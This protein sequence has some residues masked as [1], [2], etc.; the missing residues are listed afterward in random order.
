MSIIA[1]TMATK[2]WL[3]KRKQVNDKIPADMGNDPYISTDFLY[4]SI[5]AAQDTLLQ[6]IETLSEEEMIWRPYPET[7]STGFLIWHVARVQDVLVHKYILQKPEIWTSQ[8]W[9]QQFGL[10]IDETGQDYTGEQI[11]QFVEP[12]KEDLVDYLKTT[13]RSALK[14]VE[15]LASDESKTFSKDKMMQSIRY[16]VILNTHVNLHAGAIN[17][18]REVLSASRDL[19]EIAR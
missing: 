16:L 19:P 1:I 11:A 2:H 15:F 18:I 10:P 14:A 5:E 4:G 3:R 7:P 13:F 12:Q 6:A 17:Y 9:A 8:G